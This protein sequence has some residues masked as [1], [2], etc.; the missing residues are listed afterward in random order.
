MLLSKERIIYL[1][2]TWSNDEATEAEQQELFAWVRESGNEAL[3]LMHIQKLIEQHNP[4][5]QIH[6]VDWDLLYE[7]VLNKCIT[8]KQHSP[9]RRISWLSWSAA[10]VIIILLG[11]SAYLYYPSSKKEIAAKTIQQPVIQDVS[12]PVKSKAILTLADGSK[13][14]LDSISNGTLAQQGNVRVVK[15]ADG[16]ITYTGTGSEEL[17]NTLNVPRG[18]KVVTI[19]LSDGTIVWLNS[20]SSLRYPASFTGKERKVEITGEA[21]FEVAHDPS[22]P[23]I[24]KKDAMEIKVLG[25][26]FNINTYE[27]ERINKVTLL[28]GSIKIAINNHARLIKPGQQAQV[29]DEIKLVDGINTEEV[30]AWKNGLFQFGEKADLNIIMRKIARWYDVTVDYE[31]GVAD[32]RFGGEIPMNSNLSQVLEIL[33]TSGVKFTI[34]GKKVIVKP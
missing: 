23:F 13:V 5:D 15:Q 30:M 7:Q 8:P 34:D 21:Y 31:G 6:P 27:E 26:H 28:E 25:T 17:F 22:V 32:Q 4:I 16:Q 1:L 18:S 9:V 11:T 19:K 33:R 29:N 20:E 10:A 14:E 12:A 3:L 2:N 24:V